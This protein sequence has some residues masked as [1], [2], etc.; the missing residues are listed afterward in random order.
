MIVRWW[1]IAYD[2]YAR[3]VQ[4]LNA[5]GNVEMWL[6]KVEEAMFVN[7]R[8][9]V[10]IAIADFY[11]KDREQWVTIH[12]SQ[13]SYLPLLI[14]LLLSLSLYLSIS[15]SPY[16]SASPSLP[17]S[18]SLLIYLLLPLSLSLSICFS[19]WYSFYLFSRHPLPQLFLTL[20]CF[21]PTPLVSHH[22]ISPPPLPS[23]S[24]F[25]PLLSLHIPHPI[26]F[27]SL[28]QNIATTSSLPLPFSLY[29]S[30]ASFSITLP[31]PLLLT[32]NHRIPPYP[33]HLD[34]LADHVV[35]QSYR[36]PWRWDWR[37][38]TRWAGRFWT[39]KLWR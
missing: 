7:L 37:E 9:L 23:I 11:K 24:F 10:K 8:K 27:I 35:S 26:P 36:D 25:F 2:S 4:G 3:R 31:I 22:Y 12:S 13:V 16:L 15:L 29:L 6:F 18:V 28:N 38:S 19:L 30:L 5:R 21:S 1:F 32:S 34:C 17:L 20:S 33:G 14:S 39:E